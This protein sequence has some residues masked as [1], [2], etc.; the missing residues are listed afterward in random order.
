MNT[1]NVGGKCSK[2]NVATVYIHE[3]LYFTA[4]IV[5]CLGSKPT[6]Q[7]K[8]PYIYYLVTDIAAALSGCF[9]C[10]V[11]EFAYLLTYLLTYTPD[12]RGD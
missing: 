3:T 8:F 11:Y 9:S 1:N 10:A 6:S 4:V 5:G 7:N 2:I 12:P